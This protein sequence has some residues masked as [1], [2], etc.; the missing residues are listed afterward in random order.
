MVNKL[1]INALFLRCINTTFI[2]LIFGLANLRIVAPM[3]HDQNAFATFRDV[4][5]SPPGTHKSARTDVQEMY[6]KTE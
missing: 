6:K 1:A 3:T 2:N 4:K 5:P